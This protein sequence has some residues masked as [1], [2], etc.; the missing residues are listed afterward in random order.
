M[1]DKDKPKIIIV[2]KDDKIV[3]YKYRDALDKQDIYRVAALW[4]TNSRGQILLARRHR[5]KK[6]HPR[7]WGPAV[8][9]TV[10]EGETYEINII[11]EAEEELGLEDIQ[12]VLGPKTETDDEFHHFTQWYILNIDKNENE[13]KIQA[14]EVEEVGWFETNELKNKLQ[15]QPEEFLPKMKEYLEWFS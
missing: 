10:D 9:G 15:R 11:K 1:T 4:V 12:P 8:A 13:F 14:D 2:D 6:N 5:N 3:G 7:K